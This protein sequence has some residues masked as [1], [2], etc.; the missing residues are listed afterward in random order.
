MQ[1]AEEPG[2]TWQAGR[3]PEAGK[4]GSWRRGKRNQETRK[5]RKNLRKCETWIA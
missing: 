3:E 5:P 2:K 4:P 1:F